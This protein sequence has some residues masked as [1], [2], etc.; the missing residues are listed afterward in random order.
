MARYFRTLFFIVATI[1]GGI[2]AYSALVDKCYP[3]AVVT[4]MV[5]G[6]MGFRLCLYEIA[7]D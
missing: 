7:E 2:S 3:L 4:A 6:F 5:V 1:F